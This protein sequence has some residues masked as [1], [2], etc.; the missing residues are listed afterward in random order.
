MKM[1][2]W[3]KRT[4][5]RIMQ[6][7]SYGKKASSSESDT[8]GDALAAP[9]HLSSVWKSDAHG[10]SQPPDGDH[11]TRC[12]A[13]DPQS[14]SLPQSGLSALPPAHTSRGRGRM[15]T[16]AWRIRARRDRAGGDAALPAAA[17]HPPNPRGARAA[18]T[19]GGPTQRDRSA[20]SL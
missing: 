4:S 2:D 14:L 11:L 15:G 18:R 5:Q 6:E 19:A 16:A 7:V 1:V 13:V 10:S 8:T 9:D 12:H 17:Q 3:R 20:L